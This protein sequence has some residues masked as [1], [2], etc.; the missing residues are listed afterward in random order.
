MYHRICTAIFEH[1][2]NN[3]LSTGEIPD[4][5]GKSILCPLHKKS[6]LY[7][8]DNFR[9]ISLI[10]TMC[11]IFSNILVSRLNRWTE[12]FNVMYE[13]QAGFSQKYSK[14]AYFHCMPEY[15]NIYVRK[16]GDFIVCIVYRF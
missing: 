5:W 11:K 6:S 9:R 2:F 13:C 12:E 14:I 10:N 3:I 15:R 1:C 8:P 7:D 4:S 16:R